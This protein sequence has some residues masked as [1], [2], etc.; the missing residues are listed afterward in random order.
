[1]RKTCGVGGGGGTGRVIKLV[2]YA[3]S[4]GVVISGQGPGREGWNRKR[5]A[6]GVR[7]LKV[8]GGGS[9]ERVADPLYYCGAM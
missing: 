1:M 6:E 3:N 4:T 9:T 7:Q 8:G 2:F 5:G